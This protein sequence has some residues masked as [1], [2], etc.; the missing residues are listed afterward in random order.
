M[1]RMLVLSTEDIYRVIIYQELTTDI[2]GNPN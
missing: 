1:L 2:K